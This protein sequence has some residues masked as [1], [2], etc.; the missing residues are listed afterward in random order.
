VLVKIPPKKHAGKKVGIKIPPKK[1]RRAKK[2]AKKNYAIPCRAR[3]RKRGA[4]APPRSPVA[5][6]VKVRPMQTWAARVLRPPKSRSMGGGGKF[7]AV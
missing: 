1:T 7:T 4:L 5:L 2:P 3:V 6:T